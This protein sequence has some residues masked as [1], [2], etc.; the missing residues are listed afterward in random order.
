M[1]IEQVTLENVE[2]AVSVYEA[3]WR[4]SHKDV[5]TPEFLAKRDCRGYLISRIPHMYLVTDDIP[6]G[7][8]YLSDCEIADLYIQPDCRN[9]GYGKRIIDFAKKK[10]NKLTLIVLSSNCNAIRF[11]EREGFR[12]TGNNKLIR[13]GL[14]E[15]E[16]QFTEKSSW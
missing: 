8:F 10:C 15:Q 12:F 7:V 14:W 11:Y 5:C 2:F 3:A 16:M 13:M 4:E 1:K 9:K 6:V